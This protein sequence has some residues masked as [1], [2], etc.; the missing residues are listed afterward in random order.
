MPTFFH[1]HGDLIFIHIPKC[2][3]SS[4]RKA[5]AECQQKTLPELEDDV[6]RYRWHESFFEVQE[7]FG[8]WDK[9]RWEQATV[10]ATI[11]HPIERA[12]SWWKYR[13]R[14]NNAKKPST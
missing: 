11:R 7:L 14:K 12:V 10:I 8:K 13:K 2:A 6:F 1:G 4:V 3:G 5:L 9:E